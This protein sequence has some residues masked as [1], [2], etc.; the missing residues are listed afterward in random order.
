MPSKIQP[1]TVAKRHFFLANLDA[2]AESEVAQ[3]RIQIPHKRKRV[4]I[5]FPHSGQIPLM[6]PVSA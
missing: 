2:H 4:L 5:A 6:F 1:F 3:F